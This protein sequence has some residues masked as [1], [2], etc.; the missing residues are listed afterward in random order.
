MSVIEREVRVTIEHSRARLRAALIALALLVP[1][2]MHLAA[3]PDGGTATPGHAAPDTP[4]EVRYERAAML[5]AGQS[6]GWHL[7]ASVVPHWL[8]GSGKFWF[9]EETLGG[10]RFTLVDATERTSMPAFDHEALARRLRGA[11]GAEIDVNRLPVFNLWIDARQPVMTFEGLGRK[12]RYDTRRNRL[13][14]IG[15]LPAPGG[16]API[17][18]P[19]GTME[20]FLKEHNLW[21]RDLRTCEETQLT[22]DG[23]PAYAYATTPSATGRPEFL[24]SAAWSP[25]SSKILTHQTDERQVTELPLV[26]FVPADGS[27]RPKA[28]TVRSALPGDANVPMFRMTIIDVASRRQI[29]VLYQDLVAARMLDTPIS[30]NRAWWSTDSSTVYLVDIE[31]FEKAVHV[32][33]VDAATGRSRKLFTE[34]NEAGYVELGSSVYSPA[35]LV[36]LP[37]TNELVWYS[38]RT[39]WAHLYLYSLET[40][41]LIRPLTAGPW[42]VRDILGVDEERRELFFTRGEYPGSAD[43]YHRQVMRVNLDSG[44]LVALSGSDADHY[45]AHPA[46]FFIALEKWTGTKDAGNMR[47]LSP[48]GSFY[49]ESIQRIDRP[50]RTV[51]RDRNGREL[52]TIVESDTSRLPEWYRW[53]EPVQLTAAD[54][55]TPISAVVFHPSTLSPDRKYPVIDHV[56]GG[57]QV[58]YVPEVPGN[59]VAVRSAALAELG[60]V[61]VIVDGRGTTQRSRA[62][63]E[64]SYGAIQDASNME[65][66][67]AAIRQLAERYPYMD[68][69]RVGIFGFSG[70]GYMAALAMMRYPE[71]FSV[72]VAGSGNY[73]Q[74]L[75]WA[76][77]GERYHGRLEG[78]NYVPQ[79]VSTYAGNL[80]G[81]LLFMQGLM[82][83]GIHP[84]NLFQLTQKL[85][86]ANKDFDTILLPQSGH[87]SNGWAE[88][89]LWE[90]FLRHLAGTDPLPGYELWSLYDADRQQSEEMMALRYGKAVASEDA[91]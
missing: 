11:T 65:D 75:F 52:M 54:G 57:P 26:N 40:G 59:N 77:W 23:E 85:I 74:R 66:H 35:V 9:R 12:W 8:E 20:V 22:T 4:L 44:E 21:L 42:L 79:A 91:P 19:D 50:V 33:A 84:S 41:E 64:S 78:D 67:I 80:Q 86:D 17:V 29:P 16:A 39:G 47:G 58:S 89:Q 43:P 34:S 72:G 3:Q 55:E 81:K 48:D 60:F 87:T 49:V 73:D 76:T 25:D 24:V 6:R 5:H 82:D 45:V 53:P 83:V 27:L 14:D 70:G 90:Y 15:K 63:H 7:N 88:R 61:V 56:Y 32:V 68:A 1:C 13:E 28:F 10:Y 69:T 2:P 37:A 51:L 30:G 38:E 31:R 62:F 18:S 36:P 71:F 46:E